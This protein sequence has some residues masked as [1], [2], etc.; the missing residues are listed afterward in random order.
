MQPE[1]Q[2]S[3]DV[4]VAVRVSDL[5]ERE[6]LRSALSIIKKLTAQFDEILNDDDVLADYIVTKAESLV[7]A[8]NIAIESAEG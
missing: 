8:I 3:M 1:I 7:A 4:E 2:D 5:M 6:R